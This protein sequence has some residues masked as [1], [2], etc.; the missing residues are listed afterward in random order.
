MRIAMLAPISWRVPPRH[1]GPWERVVHLLTE[2]LVDRGVDVTL[3]AT[4]DS[5]TRAKLVAVCPRPYSEDP[6]LDVKVWESLHIAEAFERAADFDLIHNH[7]D[8]LP[9]TYS[10]LVSTPL[11]T[12]IHGFSSPR[13]LPVYQKYNGRVYYVAISQA[14]RR[15][16]LDYIAT[17]HH[18]IPVHEYRLSEVPGEYL[19]FFGR[20]HHEKGTV[21]AIETARRFG[22]R[23]IIAGII[24]DQAYFDQQVAPRLLKDHVEYIGPVGPEQHNALLGGAYALLHL[25]NFA[26]PFGLSVIEAMA[27]GTPVVAC[28]RGALPELV[29]HEVT[30]FLVNSVDEAVEALKRIPMIERAACRRVVEQRFSQDRMVSDYLRVYEQILARERHRARP[31]TRV[32]CE[33]PVDQSNPSDDD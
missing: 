13:I 16:E 3:L 20:I 31:R 2:G 7:F 26:E 1:Y 18:G 4:A 30:G 8:F 9:L 33:P 21:E 5:Q 25:I 14:D 15:P 28:G 11:L 12:T 6:H 19:L 23:L 24:Q 27:C 29:Q 22:M 32:V 17:I 10:A